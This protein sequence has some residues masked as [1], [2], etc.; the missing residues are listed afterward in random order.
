MTDIEM[1]REFKRRVKVLPEKYE[2][3]LIENGFRRE[4]NIFKIFKLI[5]KCIPDV[6]EEKA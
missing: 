5:E 1:W 6:D 2:I 3:A 4:P